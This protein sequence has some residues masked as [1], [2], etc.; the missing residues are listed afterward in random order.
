MKKIGLFSFLVALVFLP[1]VLYGQSAEAPVYKDGDK[2]EF[3]ATTKEGITSTTDLLEGN[4]EIVFVKGHLEVFQI[5]GGQ[6]MGATAGAAEDLKRLI[7]FGQ[8]DL[9]FLN[10]PLSIGKK[11]TVDYQHLQAGARK[12]Q[13]RWAS[14]HVEKMEQ[15]K[16]AGGE[17]QALRISGSGQTYGGRSDV[18][19]EWIYYYSPDTKS[20]IKF[21]YDSGVGTKSGK[22][23]IE[24]TKFSPSGQ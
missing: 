14:F 24:M 16:T 3:K 12:P 6:K 21:H 8:D 19:R 13:R 18:M 20:I 1:H 7:A 17:F 4:Y 10:F 5:V 11:W 9:Q 2:W 23:E 15:V 22:T